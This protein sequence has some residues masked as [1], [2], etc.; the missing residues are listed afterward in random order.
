MAVNAGAGLDAQGVLVQAGG[1]VDTG[2]GPNK[3]ALVPRPAQN[4]WRRQQGTRPATGASTGRPRTTGTLVRSR[5]A[6]GIAQEFLKASHLAS[7]NSAAVRAQELAN[8]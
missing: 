4:S 6:S 5:Q 2:E 3:D 7:A 1:S 8:V